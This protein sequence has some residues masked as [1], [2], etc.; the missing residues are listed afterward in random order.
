MPEVMLV[1]FNAV[2]DVPIPNKL[3]PAVNVSCLVPKVVAREMPALY[4]SVQ[5]IVPLTSNL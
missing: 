5:L 1:A 4:I 2:I 3:V